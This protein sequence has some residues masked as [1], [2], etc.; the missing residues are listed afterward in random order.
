M[1]NRYG[2][3]CLALM[4]V[5]VCAA[6]ENIETPEFL[7]P[8]GDRVPI[9]TVVPVYPERALRDRIQGQVEVC[10]NIDRA[11]RTLRIAVRKSTHR[12]F[13]KPAI[14]AVRE[15]SYQPLA[16]NEVLSGV[17]TCRTFRFQ[18]NPVAIEDP[19]ESS[20]DVES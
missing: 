2:P 20:V 10:F 13:E 3:L 18:L 19:S 4:L 14:N 1:S 8:A 7:E 15:S 6:Q 17:K 11:G 16:E 12:M 9:Q 5:G